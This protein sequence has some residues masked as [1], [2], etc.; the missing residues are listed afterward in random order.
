[1]L[2][3]FFFKLR[4]N[5]IPASITEYLS[6]LG[7][8]EAQ[9]CD[10]RVDSFYHLARCAL[11]KDERH[12]DRYDQTFAEYFQGAENLFEAIAGDI[13][14]EWL[15]KQAERHLSEAEKR[16]IESLGGWGK[17]LETLRKRLAEQHKRHQGGSKMIGTAGTSPF[18]AYGYNPEG[19]R[20]GQ[21]ESRHRRAVKV[22]DK[23]EF[24]NLDDRLALG[25]RNLQMA[26]RRLRKFAR[27]GAAEELDLEGTIKGT[28]KNAGLLDIHMI[29][30]RHNAIKVLLFFDVGGS[31]NDHVRVCEGLFSAARSE[32]R[33]LEYHYFHNFIYASV[34]N[35]NQRRRTQ[36]LALTELMRTY[37]SDHKLIFVG[38]ATMSPYE[39]LYPGG[40]I[41]HWNEQAGAAWMQ[42]LLDHY[43]STV[44][45]NPEPEARWDHTPSIQIIR[46]L[47]NEH[48]YPLTVNGIECAMCELL[49]H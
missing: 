36:R 39:I 15:R 10:Y 30:E 11:V 13:P 6:L 25:T 26:L 44:W 3:P 28:A 19:V 5:G 31:M 20:I 41:E 27:Q 49:A 42:R 8:L 18:G 1:M 43:P 23:R 47:L 16:K 35:N 22:W 2:M 32:F 4:Q 9:V 14:E 37:G 33:H 38:D 45:L 46:E 29:P 40:S 7:A 24:Q 21:H 12:Y 48:M 17:L 34:W